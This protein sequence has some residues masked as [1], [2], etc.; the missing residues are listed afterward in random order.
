MASENASAGVTVESQ[1]ESSVLHRVVV[2]VDAPRVRRAFDRAYRDLG[3]RVRV[4]G[5]RPGKAPRSVLE[6]LYGASVAEEIEQALVAETLADAVQQAGLDVVTEPAIE[7][8][9]PSPD[10][11][12][13][14]TARIEVKPRVELPSLDGLP[15]RMPLV[16]VGDDD[17]ERE[18]E[19]LRQR[20]AQLVEEPEGVALTD[21]HVA[22]VDFVGRV[23]GQPFEGGRGEGVE[24]LVGSGRSL[25]GFEAGL[26]GARS[27]EDREVTVTLPD[28][29]AR[30]ELAGKLAVFSVHVAAIKRR[31]VPT[32]D[33]EF[34]K[35]LGEFDSLD[36]LRGRLRQ[37]LLAAREREARAE[38]DRT[39]LDALIERTRFEVPAGMVERQ[40]EQR[41]HS[42]HDRLAGHVPHAALHEQ[43]GRWRRE[44]RAAAEREVR[45]ALLL[46]AVARAEQLGVEPAEVEARIAEM[47]A[48][49]GVSAPRLRQAWGEGIEAAV[50]AQLRDEKALEF[51]GSRA[52]V[53]VVSDT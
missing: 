26:K 22:S 40:L 52:K 30:P 31:E 25:P 53:E 3:R 42:A 21:G 19:A 43:M 49:Q 39:L 4:R 11:S 1:A 36:A 38:R 24:L 18:L 41:L 15:A 5:F 14:Y 27:G 50:E 20:H 10:R 45:E 9:P 35:D 48:R 17:V 37:D 32:L 51:L 12:F 29:H 16:S 23:D 47:A 44:W 6:R 28:D 2:E 46:E 33:D 8:S 7:A 13:R 34:A